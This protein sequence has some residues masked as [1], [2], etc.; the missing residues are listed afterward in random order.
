M[1]EGRPRPWEKI[2]PG[3]GSDRYNKEPAYRER[4][5]RKLAAELDRRQCR[6][7]SCSRQEIKM[8]KWPSC[9]IFERNF[10][11]RKITDAAL[12]LLCSALFF[13][14]SS[15]PLYSQ[16]EPP[17]IQ[18]AATVPNSKLSPNRPLLV[19]EYPYCELGYGPCGGRCSSEEGKKQWACPADALPCFQGGQ[20][21]TCEAADMCKPKKK[22]TTPG[23]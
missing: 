14:I 1:V 20:R 10:I 13:V 16:G 6:Q 18:P 22:K 17:S 9:M 11:A 15:A 4:H 12:P 19:Q 21:C 5:L 7:A 23:P 3:Q 2:L 8:I